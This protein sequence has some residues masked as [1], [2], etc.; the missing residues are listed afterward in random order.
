MGSASLVLSGR[1]QVATVAIGEVHY[2]EV[3]HNQGV[4]PPTRPHL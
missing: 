3:A 1:S 4:D 2:T